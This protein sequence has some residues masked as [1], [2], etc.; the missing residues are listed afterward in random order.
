MT[1]MAIRQGGSEMGKGRKEITKEIKK[2]MGKVGQSN[3]K[4][5]W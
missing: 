4:R 1:I 3:K 2:E 5:K